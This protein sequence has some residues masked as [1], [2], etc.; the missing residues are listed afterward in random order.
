MDDM[1]KNCREHCQMSMKSMD[2]LAKTVADAKASNDPAKMR[3]AL[4][5]VENPHADM[6]QHMNMCMNMMTMMQNMQRMMGG[7]QQAPHQ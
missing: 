1:M 7:Q 3:A 6:R 2:G 4:D 5:Q